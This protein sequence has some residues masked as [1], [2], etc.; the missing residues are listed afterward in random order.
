MINLLIQ[1]MLQHQNW[2]TV[3]CHQKEKQNTSEPFL[4]FQ[5]DPK[6]LITDLFTTIR[7]YYY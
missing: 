2:G 3:A 7:L 6:L 5:G 1:L 4:L